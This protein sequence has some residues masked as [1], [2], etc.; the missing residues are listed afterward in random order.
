LFV[1]GTSGVSGIFEP[2]MVSM[3]LTGKCRTRLIGVSTDGDDRLYLGV[4]EFVEVFGVM[5][6][7]VDADFGHR[8]NGEGMDVAS[9]FGSGAG[10]F[11]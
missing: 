3:D 6:R 11:K 2:P 7:Q 4:K 8:A 10:D 9:R 1:L 5:S